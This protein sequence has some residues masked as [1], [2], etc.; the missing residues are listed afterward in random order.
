MRG[1]L[2]LVNH[3]DGTVSGGLSV[4]KGAEEMLTHLEDY[5]ALLSDLNIPVTSTF[6][7]QLASTLAT[8]PWT[9][10]GAW[11]S[12]SRLDGPRVVLVG[13]AAHAVS[14]SLGQGCNA[15]LEDVQLLDQVVGEAGGCLQEVP[16]RFSAL[17]LADGNALVWLD[18]NA[19]AMRGQ[20]GWYHPCLFMY[21]AHMYLRPALKRVF[22]G[23]GPP[24]MSR[25]WSQPMSY[26]LVKRDMITDG[27]LLGL[28][29][30][31]L[32]LLLVG[33]AVCPELFGRAQVLVA[34]F[35][36]TAFLAGVSNS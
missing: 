6:R 16:A 15:A 9:W 17:R 18:R 30:L 11:V 22:L 7:Q 29:L 2:A 28:A 4:Y 32:L 5:Q 12:C 31:L 25:L 19:R 21:F 33:V 8:K 34:A 1:F 3:E 26:T 10:G 27:A 24:S 14:P 13:D 20:Q 35:Q 23:V 36:R